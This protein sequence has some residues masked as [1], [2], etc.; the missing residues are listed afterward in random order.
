VAGLGHGE[1]SRMPG[2]LN[3]FQRT[4]LQWNDLHPYNAVH[5]LRLPLAVDVRRVQ[6]AIEQTVVR[7]GLTRL[8]L[9][10]AAGTYDYGGGPTDCPLKLVPFDTDPEAALA[11]EVTRQLNTPFDLTGRF[12]PFRFFLLAAP[13]GS[14]LGVAYFHAMAGA[15]SL[16]LL[17]RDIACACDLAAERG[18]WPPVELHPPAH[19]DWLRRHPGV[20]LKKLLSLPSVW[21]ELRRACVPKYR[22]VQVMTNG[23]TAFALPAETLRRLTAA[24]KTWGVTLNDLFLAGLMQALTPLAETR[25]QKS[26]RRR[27]ALGCIVNTRSHLGVDSRRTF[28]L[29]LGSF[30]V[31]HEAPAGISLQ[32][33]ATDLQRQ[34]ARIKRDRL[35]MATPVDLAL[36]RA[37]LA[38]TSP[39]Q[40]KKFYLKRYPLWGGVTNMNLNPLW[41]QPAGT[42]AVDY[43]RAVSTGPVTPLVLS[44]TTV[45]EVVNIGLTYRTSVF[46]AGEIE[47][48]K[49][50]FLSAVEAAGEP[51]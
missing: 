46:T 13:D 22:E 32:A 41:P 6:K 23:F 25:R 9:D 29:F 42:P 20:L 38:L 14:A 34:T 39:G 17:L 43:F 21:R 36:A 15:E 28:G 4:M 50:G 37:Y 40:R 3:S 49:T 8:Q 2:R 35:F 31:S 51:R 30:L 45:G 1:L 5:V 44:L 16:V 48:V 27:L 10:R 18:L 24:S 12:L 7:H 11:D 19:R 26:R 47:R 33:L